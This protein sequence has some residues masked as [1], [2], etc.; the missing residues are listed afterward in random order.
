M[1]EEISDAIPNILQE[2]EERNSNIARTGS[3]QRNNFQ[4][5]R[6]GRG[7]N[8][9]YLNSNSQSNYS[10]PQSDYSKSQF[11]SSSKRSCS[12]CNATGRQSTSHYLSS[13]PYLSAEDK[14][15]MNSSRT[16]EVS[17]LP[18]DEFSQDEELEV[19]TERSSG[20]NTRMINVDKV[21]YDEC[22]PI[23]NV[24]DNFSQLCGVRRVDV[25]ASPVLEVLVNSL[26]SRWTLD[27][28]AEANVI[29]I[30]ECNRLG[31]EIQPTLQG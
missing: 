1:R 3:Y 22:T 19:D 11:N 16:R 4:R 2:L 13:C 10:N 18:D 21:P 20:A 24:V 25:F 26:L 15:F 17:L 27:S 8:Q 5:N 6:G 30:E 29:T 28:G 23:D 12:L 7:R 14:K 9:N 31:L